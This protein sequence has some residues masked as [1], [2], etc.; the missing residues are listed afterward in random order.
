M[1]RTI[2]DWFGHSLT[3]LW[4]RV[5][6]LAGFAALA[7]GPLLDLANDPAINTQVQA[8]L[9]PRYVPFY[10]IGIGITTELA[11]WRTAGKVALIAGALWLAAPAPAAAGNCLIA[12]DSIAVGLGQV[13][14]ECATDARIGISSAAVIARIGPAG[15]LI[16]SA[17]SNDPHNPR[18]IANL[19][20]I[21]AKAGGRVIWIAP[22]DRIAA[23]AVRA[24]AGIHGDAVIGFA[25][26]A[27][28]VHPRGYGD[29]A[30]QVRALMAGAS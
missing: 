11:R 16:V 8:L 17:G 6:A 9:D 26:A 15:V 25:P 24:V 1:G 5:V 29:M 4:A 23:A 19:K 18:L 2:K 20:V 12:G 13:M 3:I 22:V 14:R 28:H 30:R 10:L 21:R 7:L 27:D